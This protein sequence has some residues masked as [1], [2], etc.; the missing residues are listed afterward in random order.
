MYE[1]QIFALVM[2]ILYCM[3]LAL[4]SVGFGTFSWEAIISGKS[5]KSKKIK[6]RKVKIL[7]SYNA[8]AQSAVAFVKFS[9]CNMVQLSHFQI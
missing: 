8:F 2:N 9:H 5:E 1:T 6:Y 3:A 4:S 7:P